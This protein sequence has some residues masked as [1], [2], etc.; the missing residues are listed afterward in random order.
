MAILT[1][2]YVLFCIVLFIGFVVGSSK[3]NIYDAF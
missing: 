3:P 2:V 1:E